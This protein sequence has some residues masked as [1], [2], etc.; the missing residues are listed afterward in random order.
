MIRV[1]WLELV[2]VGCV[3]K[4]GAGAGWRVNPPSGSRNLRST[5]VS[6]C[7]AV[8]PGFVWRPGTL[9]GPFATG[10]TLVW[11]SSGRVLELF[12]RLLRKANR[13]WFS[14]S[15]GAPLGLMAHACTRWNVRACCSIRTWWSFNC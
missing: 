15:V 1:R 14:R 11:R 4:G 3:Q 12:W 7:P 9:G 6:L 10:L 2:V 5:T 13:G 8:Q